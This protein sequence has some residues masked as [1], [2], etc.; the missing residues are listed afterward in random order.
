MKMLPYQDLILDS[1]ICCHII[2][3]TNESN[4]IYHSKRYQK[5]L[6]EKSNVNTLATI[7]LASSDIV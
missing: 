4:K 6:F 7:G 2:R 1:E 5:L 3:I